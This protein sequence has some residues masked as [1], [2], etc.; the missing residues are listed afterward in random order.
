MLDSLFL[1]PK[2]KYYNRLSS[3][4]T[5]L[6]FFLCIFFICL[7]LTKTERHGDEKKKIKER[8]EKG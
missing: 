6:Y 7:I 4:F 3:L 2:M 1:K 8:K 5:F